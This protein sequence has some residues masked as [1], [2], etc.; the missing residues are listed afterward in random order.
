MV[1]SLNCSHLSLLTTI[2]A[3][4][5]QNLSSGERSS[6]F[7]LL[8]S[9]A[10]LGTLLTGIVGSF[11]LDYFG[12]Q[13]AF[14][15]IGFLGITWA[16]SMRFYAMSSDRNRVINLSMQNRLT[17]NNTTTIPSVPWLQIFKKSSFWSMVIAHAC[18]N[19]CFFVLLSWLP[20]Y[21]HDGFPQAKVYHYFDS[22]VSRNDF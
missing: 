3:F 17:T 18:Q 11:L 2:S 19:N 22:A 9:G 4:I 5:P 16:L 21:F 10:A 20:T 7:S 15:I 8:T 14:R 12:W 13:M 1:F 6:F